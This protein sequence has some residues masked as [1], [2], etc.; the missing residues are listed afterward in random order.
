MLQSLGLCASLVA[1]AQAIMIPS[2]VSLESIKTTGGRHGSLALVDPYTQVLQVGCPGC[3][4]AQSTPEREAGFIWTQGVENNLL[5]NISVGSQPETLELNGVRFYPPILSLTTE[6][7]VPY[8]SQVPAGHSLSEIR[9]HADKFASKPLRLT[10][11]SFAAATSHTVNESGEEILTI[12][13]QLNALERQAV[14]VPD[15]TITALKNTDAQLMLLKIDTAEAPRKPQQC[16][17]WPLLCKWRGIVAARLRGFRGK[18]HG[19]HRRPHHAGHGMHPGGHRGMH[20]GGPAHMGQMEHG[21]PHHGMHTGHGHHHHH[22]RHHFRPIVRIIGR[23]FL[24][25]GMTIGVVTFIFNRMRSNRARNYEA[26]ALEE[27]YDE[28]RKSLE[29]ALYVDEEAVP[30]PPVYVEVE[31]KELGVQ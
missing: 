2:T 9:K 24:F 5:L 10:S 16:N 25:L 21:N 22:H 6:P 8:I 20:H 15:I 4:F 17:D 28:P 18:A 7:P 31:A 27:E 19:C 26:V 23:A 12:T 3:M 1:L 13:L 30:S 14:T 11:W 29:K